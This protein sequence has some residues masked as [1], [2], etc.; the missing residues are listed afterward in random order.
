MLKIISEKQRK[1]YQGVGFSQ[2]TS[3]IEKYIE[4]LPYSENKLKI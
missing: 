2:N 3:K 1:I 4:K